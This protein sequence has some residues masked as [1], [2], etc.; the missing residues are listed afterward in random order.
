MNLPLWDC[1]TDERRYCMERA[2]PG[3]WEVLAA[4]IVGI[5]IIVIIV[6]VPGGRP[7]LSP[8]PPLA[9]APRGSPSSFLKARPPLAD[10]AEATWAG[11]WGVHSLVRRRCQSPNPTSVSG[12]WA[13]SVRKETDMGPGWGALS[14][15]GTPFIQSEQGGPPQGA[16]LERVRKRTF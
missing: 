12:V 4:V 16:S 15:A 13:V 2:A 6:T 10:T 3:T 5:M 11:K 14:R 9:L 8:K 7:T 1:C